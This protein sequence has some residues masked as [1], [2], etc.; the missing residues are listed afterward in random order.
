[1]IYK[2]LDSRVTE[3]GSKIFADIKEQYK[4]QK[5]LGKK[6]IIK[7]NV[8]L[9]IAATAIEIEAVLITNDTKDDILTIIKTY[10]SDFS[11]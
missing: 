4:E 1:M 7:Q 8:D 3:K 6:A 11:F 10:R 9:M 5:G 2:K